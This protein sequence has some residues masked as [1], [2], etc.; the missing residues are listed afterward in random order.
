MAQSGKE[1]A[2]CPAESEAP[3]T[4]TNLFPVVF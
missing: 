2:A 4:E 3:G 1:L